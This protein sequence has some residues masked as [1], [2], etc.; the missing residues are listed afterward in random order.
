M[1]IP[2]DL[3]LI[4]AAMKG[5]KPTGFVVSYGGSLNS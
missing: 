3:D 5:D 2:T 1:D 4:G